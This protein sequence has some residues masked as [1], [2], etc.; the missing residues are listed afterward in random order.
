M[1]TKTIFLAMLTILAIAFC[2]YAT[3]TNSSSNIDWGSQATYA[4]GPNNK[5][6]LFC[7]EAETAIETGQAASG[8]GGLTITGGAV[9]LNASSNY[10]VNI[11]TGTSTG[12]ITL[13]NATTTQA[14]VLAAGT[15]DLTMSS[16]DDVTLNG[17]SAGSIITIGGNTQG[18]VINIAADNTTADTI[19]IGS[20]KDPITIGGVIQGASPL[21]L[22]GATTTGTTNRTTI[23]V[24]DPTAARTVTIPDKSGT[25][26]LSSAASALSLSSGNATLTVGLS[27]L[28]TY[29]VASDNQDGTITFSGAGTA[30]DEITILFATDAGAGD[31]VITFHATLVSSV[32]TLTLAGTASR[33]YTVTFISDGSHWYEKCRTAIQ[34]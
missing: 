27:N 7:E 28:Y 3:M 19:T 22:D 8:S 25:V 11:A 20:A 16:V 32:G 14:I 30:G 33:Y 24:T 4:P 31:E 18:N 13:G 6:K 17:G 29:T 15:G 12:T 10:A 1:K 5:L 26:Q 9:S 34:T 21:V 2:A 23:A